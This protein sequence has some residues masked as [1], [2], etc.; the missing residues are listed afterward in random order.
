VGTHSTFAVQ[1]APQEARERFIGDK[2]YDSNKLNAKLEED[3]GIEMLA[4]N[5]R[6]TQAGRV[7]RRYRRRW[8]VK[9]LFAWLQNFRRLVVRL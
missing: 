1:K 8:K 7:L 2:A 3:W 9:L 5:R 4:P 6:K